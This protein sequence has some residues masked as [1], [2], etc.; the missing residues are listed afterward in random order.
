MQSLANVC[1]SGRQ[2]EEMW[3]KEVIFFVDKI[4]NGEE[5]QRMLESEWERLGMQG[6]VVASDITAPPEYAATNVSLNNMSQ[7]CR[8][9]IS[10]KIKQS[11]IIH[12]K[13]CAN[14]DKD[15]GCHGARELFERGEGQKREGALGGAV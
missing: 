12:G 13:T 4:N 14:H 1:V 3:K 10:L 11:K 15:R 9:E 8:H 5:W 7:A 2:L 6:D